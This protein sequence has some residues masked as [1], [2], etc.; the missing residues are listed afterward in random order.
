M[1]IG[2]LIHEYEDAGHHRISLS[3]SREISRTRFLLTAAA[4]LVD[5][6]YRRV[7]KLRYEE[8]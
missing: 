8:L 7:C 3:K 2:G 6:I 1:N 5:F 4:Q